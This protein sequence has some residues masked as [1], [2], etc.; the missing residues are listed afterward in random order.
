M[1]GSTLALALAGS[2]LVVGSACCAEPASDPHTARKPIASTYSV[3][4]RQGRVRLVA[5]PRS[6]SWPYSKSVWMWGSEDEPPKRI[7]VDL[8]I[9]CE[10]RLVRFPF[11]SYADL[12]EPRSI[13]FAP[14]TADSVLL[15][16]GGHTA[17]SYIA[18]FTLR[19]GELLKRKV[20]LKE[21]PERPD[22][23]M[24]YQLDEAAK[25]E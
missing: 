18:E 25:A 23:M 6:S 1:N 22:S 13:R 12:A 9:Q 20:W 19:D 2:M 14:G 8:T 24:F 4:G 11:S 21:F 16:S 3:I 17:T 5:S 10:D 7:V 15:I